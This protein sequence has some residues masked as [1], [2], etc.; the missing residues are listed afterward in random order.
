MRLIETP[1]GAYETAV[2]LYQRRRWKEAFETFQCLADDGNV[3]AQVAVGNMYLS[4]RGVTR[5]LKAAARWLEKA[6]ALGNPHAKYSLARLCHQEGDHQR[7]R[8]LLFEAAS[9]NYFPALYWIGVSHELGLGTTPDL[10]QA[11]SLYR[12][13]ADA[14]H[15]PAR[16]RLGRLGLAGHFGLFGR[17]R[18]A[19]LSVTAYLLAFWLVVAHSADLR[20][21][22]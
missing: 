5:D 16:A 4:G 19:W 6:A 14:G 3:L 21:V 20:I 2:R 8:A 13:A 10:A 17:V 9:N 11:I 22:R 1:P 12:Q 7:A 18:G 15:V